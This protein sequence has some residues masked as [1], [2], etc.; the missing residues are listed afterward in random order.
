MDTI[1]YTA[2]RA[3]LAKMMEEVC[4]NHST[5]TITRNGDPVVVMISHEDYQALEE[6]AYLL[7]SPANRDR[8]TQAVADANIEA[9]KNASVTPLSI[10]KPT[11]DVL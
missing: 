9:E 11:E 5:L 7:R 3:N 8:L 1:S 4:A 6:S 2:V 10:A